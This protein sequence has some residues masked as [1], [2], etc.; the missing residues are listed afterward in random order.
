M[1]SPGVL[2]TWTFHRNDYVPLRRSPG[3]VPS[4]FEGRAHL[5]CSLCCFYPWASVVS[6]VGCYHANVHKDGA[7]DGRIWWHAHAYAG[8]YDI[9]N[10]YFDDYAH[11]DND[12]YVSNPSTM[13]W[14]M[15][16]HDS[17]SLVWTKV[18]IY[19][20]ALQVDIVQATINNCPT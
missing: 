7:Q 5:S 1:T 18:R 2:G 19:H 15:E 6:A 10:C 4:C 14:A 3:L 12:T 20:N 17:T 16:T 8:A 11:D 9:G 13:Y